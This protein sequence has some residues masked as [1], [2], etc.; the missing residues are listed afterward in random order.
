MIV[1]MTSSQPS[2]DNS[3]PNSTPK[4]ISEILV[5]RSQ[6]EHLVSDYKLKDYNG[7]I[8]NLKWFIKYGLR[9]NSLRPHFGKAI[10]IANEIVNEVS[11][12]ETAN[13]SSI[14]GQAK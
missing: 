9:S 4:S 8:D 1:K 7:T 13:I 6:W 3:T 12:Y 10:E 11:K 5:L 2:L 14:H